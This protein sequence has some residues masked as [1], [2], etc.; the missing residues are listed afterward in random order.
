VLIRNSTGASSEEKMAMLSTKNKLLL[1]LV[2]DN[3]CFTM[4]IVIFFPYV[5]GIGGSQ[6]Y[7]GSIM[8][9]MSLIGLIWNPMIGSLGDTYGRKVLL[10]RMSA[11]S[12]FSYTLLLISDSLVLIFISRLIAAFGGPLMPILGTAASEFLS[13]KSDPHILENCLQSCL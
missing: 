7:M 3:L 10:I 5:T 11:V 6:L 13:N 8:S 4:L 1:T 9:V 12:A 2:M